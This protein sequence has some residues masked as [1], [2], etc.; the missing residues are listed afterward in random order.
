MIRLNKKFDIF[1]KRFMKLEEDIKEIKNKFFRVMHCAFAKY[2]QGYKKKTDYV[3]SR[4]LKRSVEIANGVEKYIKR[5][6]L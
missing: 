4:N 3:E 6:D 1:L 2:D 5:L